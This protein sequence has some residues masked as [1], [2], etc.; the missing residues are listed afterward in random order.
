M[1]RIES[2]PAVDATVAPRLAVSSPTAQVRPVAWPQHGHAGDGVAGILRAAGGRRVEAARTLARACGN[3]RF[4]RM[5][6]RLPPGKA[7]M[8]KAGADWI[9]PAATLKA[10]TDVLRVALR[11]IKAGKSVAVNRTAGRT[12]LANALT[13]LGKTDEVRPSR[14]SGTG[15]WIIRGSAGT[16]VYA[17]KER[18]FIGRFD[19][20]LAELSAA[21]SGART[22]YWLKNT[23]AVVMDAVIAASNAALPP[24]PLY[25]YAAVEGLIDYVR[26]EIG[27]ADTD[28]RTAAQLA[29][30]ST[31]KADPRVNEQGRTVDSVRFPNLAMGLQALAA[32][33]KRRRALF[34]ADVSQVRLSSTDHRRA[35]IE[36][37]VRRGSRGVQARAPRDD[38]NV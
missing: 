35:G 23:P 27:L 10:E 3:R 22:V 13:T 15:P 18:V 37:K 1:P 19:T 33:I 11:E 38:R 30:V 8:G 16:A 24:A 7:A 2:K 29:S 6:S 21:H 20:P 26:H 25:S 5:L 28:E 9:D 12:R 32:S 34:L 36:A 31:S 4:V 14:R 17:A